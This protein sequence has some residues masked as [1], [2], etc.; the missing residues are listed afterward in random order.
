MVIKVK[1]KVKTKSKESGKKVRNESILKQNKRI[2]TIKM[3]RKKRKKTI[4]W[5]TSS[6]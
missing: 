1:D 3:K 5:I 4:S 2:I 6:I